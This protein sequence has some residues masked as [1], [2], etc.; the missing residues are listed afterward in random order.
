M[1]RTQRKDLV[2]AG[3]AAERKPPRVLGDPLVD[4]LLDLPFDVPVG[5]TVAGIRNG[6]IGGLVIWALLGLLL[7]FA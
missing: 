4:Q 5:D 6:V 7:S 1:G 3:S 2:V